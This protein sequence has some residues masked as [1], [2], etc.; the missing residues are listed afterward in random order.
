MLWL[1]GSKVDKKSANAHEKEPGR[2]SS[3]HVHQVQ[4]VAQ[5]QYK[6]ITKK[7]KGKMC[8]AKNPLATDAK[9]LKAE[10]ETYNFE[11]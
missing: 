6:S 7:G 1:E 9:Y 4:N 8:I 3:L 5:K 2:L 11:K 10:C